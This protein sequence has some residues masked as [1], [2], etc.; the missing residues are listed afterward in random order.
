VR[1]EPTKQWLKENKHSK[2]C[3]FGVGGQYNI[4]GE[5]TGKV[6]TWVAKCH[7]L[8]SSCD[9]YGCGFCVGADIERQDADIV[10]LCIAFPFGGSYREKV[11]VTP[12]KIT[13][14]EVSELNVILSLALMEIFNLDPDFRKQ[15]E[16]MLKQKGAL[17]RRRSKPIKEKEKKQNAG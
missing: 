9:K 6:P 11:L 5:I 2:K 3:F 1:V 8:M 14:E 16:R 7:T 15:K 4:G 17:L 12:H 13:I 10:C